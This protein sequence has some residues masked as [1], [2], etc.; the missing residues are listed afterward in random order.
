M[1]LT[2]FKTDKI[3]KT[4]ELFFYKLR[5]IFRFIF[6]WFKFCSS[7]LQ[8]IEN[9]F[10]NSNLRLNFAVNSRVEASSEDLYFVP[11]YVNLNI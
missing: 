5:Y 8:I 6:C 7:A 2:I 10:Y 3:I 1:K 9:I 4:L 11:V